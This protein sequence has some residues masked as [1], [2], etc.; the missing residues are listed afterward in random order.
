M[1]YVVPEGYQPVGDAEVVRA[2]G[3]SLLLRAG[4]VRVEIVALADG[5]FRVGMFPSGEPVQYESWAVDK[6]DWPGVEVTHSAT[7]DEAVL[8]T[9][10]A[11]C[12]VSLY[13]LRIRVTDQQGRVIVA[14]DPDLGMGHYTRASENTSFAGLTNAAV[15]MYKQRPEGE[16]Y[17]GC[18]EQASGLERT[19]N[20]Q[21]FWATDPLP[22]HS[23]SHDALYT[24]IPFLL[25]LR[26]GQAWGLFLDNAYRSEFDLAHD[27]PDQLWFGAGGAPLVY[28]VFTGPTP[29]QVLDR[30]TQLTGR[31]PMPPM[32]ALGNQQ[33]RWGYETAEQV[34]N[35]AREFRSR[36]IPCDVFHLDIDYMT[37]YRV[38]T[39]NRDRF[40]D[41][42][43]FMQ[44]MRNQ[45]FHVITIV[46]PGVKVD[47]DYHVYREGRENNL[48]CQTHDGKEY[49]NVVWPGMC[50]FPDFTSERTRSWWAE[51][52]RALLDPG[53]SG[54]WCDM[55]EPTT[56]IPSQS[57]FPADVVHPGDG[58]PRLHEEVHN[59]YGLQMARSAREGMLRFRPDQRP[60]VISRSGFAGLQR[61]ALHWTGDNSSW[62]EHLWM[63]MPQLQNLGLSGLAWTGVDVGGF[64]GDTNPELFTRF[65]E[66]GI[67]QPFCRNHSGNGTIEQEPWRF[68]EPW[69]SHLRSLLQLRQRLLPYLYTVF[70]ECHRTGA[71]ILRPLLFDHP[72][73]PTTYATDDQF[74]LGE[75]LLV[76]PITRPS[77]E[78]RHVYLPRGTWF[79][80]WSGKQFKGP[81]HILQRAPLGQPAVFV[82]ANT[83]IPLA[84]VTN[85]VGER[86]NDPLT[87]QIF[88][89]DGSGEFTLYEDAGDG[90]EY[91]QGAYSRR[92][93]RCESSYS[94]ATINLDRREGSWQPSRQEVHLQ[95]HTT[96]EAPSEILVNGQSVP[97]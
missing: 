4:D 11:V 58:T 3:S 73:D 26:D 27:Q 81:T 63:A 22:G 80:L 61:Y 39:W 83:A 13:P 71:P 52:H 38:F 23:P 97:V 28:Y 10:S 91:Q 66:F 5:L 33:S 42:A 93:I 34:L 69:E 67:F 41:P 16:R 70:E 72:D 29:A 1:T 7:A 78:Y 65:T 94:S 53:A 74:L 44:Q 82:R 77:T 37:G 21:T 20:R 6:T 84:P 96:R 19:G 60:L 87:L 51:Q 90:F 54:I 18:G 14:D 35:L 75:A 47:E 9:A 79:H 55:N 2:E 76:A 68:G 17:F 92:R 46:D 56:F 85:Y 31:T 59:V 25:A 43:G 12:R 30:Y 15:R 86:P 57:T 88:L 45:G 64:F 24:A 95:V 62:W 8:S 49:Q 50:A 89:D 40:P 36:Q 48:F 32:W